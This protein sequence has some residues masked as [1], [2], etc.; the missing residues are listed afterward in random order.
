[1]QDYKFYTNVE[2]DYSNIL[3]RYVTQDGKR[4]F[5]KVNFAP[6][7]F[8]PDTTGY[9]DSATVCDIYGNPLQLAQNITSISEARDFVKRYKGVEGFTVYGQQRYEYQ[10]IEYL[11]R[12][13]RAHP[14]KD[15]HLIYNMDI[16]VK[17]DEGFPEPDKAEKPITAITIDT[18]KKIYVFGFDEF[19]T[20]DEFKTENEEVVYISCKDEH[21]LLERFM[22]FW[23]ED[24]PDI[25]TGWNVRF[26][27][28]PYILNRI[29][30]LFGNQQALKLSPWFDIAP[31]QVDLGMGRKATAYDIKGIS[32]LDYMDLYQRYAPSGKSQPSYKLGDIGHVELG[33]S[34]LD[35]SE[36]QS[37][38]GLY[39]TDFQKYLDYNIQ[40]TAIIRG[41]E[42]KH[43]LIDLAIILAHDSGCNYNDVFT[44][45]RMWDV[46]TYRR[47]FDENIAVPPVERG[48]KDDR[49]VGAYVKEPKPG[50]YKYVVSVDLDSLYPHLMMQY[51][52]S[53]ETIVDPSE[54]GDAERN[55]I[56]SGDINVDT[57]LDEK[58][59]LD[60]LEFT[61][62]TPNKQFFKIDLQGFLPEMMET[63]Y[64]DRSLY[65]KK[66]IQ[67]K[68]TKEELISGGACS[69]DTI[70]DYD[71]Q[72]ATF[73]NLQ[74]AKKV[75]LN[76]AYGAMGNQY[77]RFYDIRLATAVTTAGQLSIRW[78][79]KHVNAALNRF[80][81][82]DNFDYIIAA[83]TDSLYINLEPVI[84]RFNPK[85]PIDF[86]DK[87]HEEFIQDVIDKAYF[88]LSE[89]VNS[90][91]Q[92]MN[93]K[94]E[95]LADRG[96]W[97][98]KKRYILNV[99]DQEGVRYSEP[100]LKISGLEAVKS[101]TPS[102]CRDKIKEALK[103]ILTKDND[104]LIKFIDDFKKE[105]NKLPEDE[106]AFPR[107]VNGLGKYGDEN[108]IFSKGT[109]IHVRGSLLYNR[110]LIDKK[111]D[112]KWETIKEGEKIK[113]IFLKEP[114]P[115]HSNVIS[116]ATLLPPELGLHQ[117]IDYETQFEKSF[118][119]PLKIVLDC[120][121]WQTEKKMTLF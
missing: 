80:M 103:I 18:F 19:N 9:K 93:M 36:A 12:N 94:R 21:D 114:N 8:I 10:Y 54:Y 23:L 70:K 31:R 64:V 53:P 45:V 100:Q 78:A 111:L 119:D 85:N 55:I 38:H 116:F 98:A 73:N 113:Y 120:I 96:L 86:M 56:V 89:Y 14:N 76:S 79:E 49:Y 43:R 39:R 118:I 50:M 88:K 47:L 46:L 51:N 7:L 27:D 109:P 106:I 58:L 11:T 35:Y 68:K 15:E 117:Y 59:N 75:C 74:L 25:I 4:M 2:K 29:A 81:K 65:K 112:R 108:S 22:V 84:E 42:N 17:S 24:Y 33:M 95:C 72:I 69:P 87:F 101:S 41:L 32:V 26:F 48:E 62:I 63:M 97:T 37:L 52:I 28:I 91:E 115:I 3:L 30:N 60:G 110:E 66:M 90:Y 121:G 77:F 6:S 44:Q 71:N 92:K 99:W 5:E 104:T 102:A 107:G 105:F 40:D 34:K 82:T 67:A 1:M 83:D 57:L 16:E 20:M 61:T 13:G